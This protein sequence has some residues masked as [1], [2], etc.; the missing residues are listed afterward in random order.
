M[1]GFLQALSALAPIAPA[2]SDAKDIRLARQQQQETFASEQ[3]L[4]QAQLTT[5]Q[6]AAEG[7]R[8]RQNQANQIKFIGDPQWNP[9]THTYQATALDPNN[10][11]IMLKDVPGPDPAA[12]AEAKYQAARTDYKK[13]TGHDPTPEED[14][15]LFF[16]SYGYKPP[17]PKITQLTGDAGK[18]Y[19]G[20]DG[21][22][23][24]NEKN[25]DG[26]IVAVPMGANYQPP[27]PKA[28]SPSAIYTNLLAK[29]ILADK[30]QGPP[31]SN[32]DAAQL[33]AAQSA[34][35]IAGIT[36]AQAWAKAAAANN[37]IAVTDPDTG[38]DTLDHLQQAA[39]AAKSGPPYSLA[40]SRRQQAWTRR[41]KCSRSR[42]SPKSTRWSAFSPPTRT[43]L[44]LD[45]DSSLV[46]RHGSEPTRPTRN[47]S[48]L[49]PLSCLSTALACSE[50]GISTRLKIYRI[51]W[52][53]CEPIPQ[54]SRLRSIK[55]DRQ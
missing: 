53:A 23:Y 28:S 10:G 17:T 21:L 19:K 33:Q 18:P 44:A 14:E 38:M 52:A 2:M 12:V 26:S 9:L 22:Y 11:N 15:S 41:T 13:V 51:S 1:G 42:R 37:L 20:N 24:V 16:Q 3:A 36:R 55:P 30:K 43:S 46:C 6:L 35:D 50:A 32:E 29:K 48:L 7:E 25:A 8:Q 39:A 4:K 49:R 45:Q 40:L 31:L 27:P 34:L 54:H 47:N 5:A